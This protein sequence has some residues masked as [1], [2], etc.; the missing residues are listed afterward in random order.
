MKSYFYNLPGSIEFLVD[1]NCGSKWTHDTEPML[2]LG[3]LPKEADSAM[4]ILLLAERFILYAPSDTTLPRGLFPG[5]GIKLP[6][7]LRLASGVTA[8]LPL[9]LRFKS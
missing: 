3:V 1:F 7:G 5:S 9:G 4:G 8:K 2:P 6:L